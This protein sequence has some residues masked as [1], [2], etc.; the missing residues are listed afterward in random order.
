MES[1]PSGYASLAAF[2][3][4]DENFTLIKRFDYLHMR[5]VLYQ[6]DQLA[7]LELK[8]LLLDANE[9]ISLNLC[10]RRQDSNEERKQL[11]QEIGQV[12]REC[13][14]GLADCLLD[15]WISNR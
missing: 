7:E 5:N 10:S 3:C 12:T 1:Y 2:L 15:S 14:R 13:G 4:L 9:K 11:M 8:L 6:Q